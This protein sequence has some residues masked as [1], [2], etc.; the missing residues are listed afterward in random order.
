MVV[1]TSKISQMKVSVTDASFG[2]TSTISPIG[3]IM[4]I[5]DTYKLFI[6]NKIKY[7][8]QVD[9]YCIIYITF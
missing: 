3:T 7:D 4:D 8:K 6:I 1:Q 9:T 5:L 2:D